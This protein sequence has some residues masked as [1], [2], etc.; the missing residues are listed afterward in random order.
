[1]A[2]PHIRGADGRVLLHPP[3]LERCWVLL[4][5][6]LLDC[7]EFVFV[8]LVVVA[9][10]TRALLSDAKNSRLEALAVQL[11]AFGARAVATLLLLIWSVL[12]IFR[13]RRSVTPTHKHTNTFV[14][15]L[16]ASY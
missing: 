16:D 7:L 1:M 9:F 6:L 3:S 8:L 15:S 4:D 11:Q 2:R 12:L 13:W 14:S 10:L 5:E